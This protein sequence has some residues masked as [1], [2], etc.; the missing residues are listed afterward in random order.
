MSKS[1]PDTNSRFRFVVEYHAFVVHFQLLR[2]VARAFSCKDRLTSVFVIGGRASLC[3]CATGGAELL[4]V[5]IEGLAVKTKQINDW[6][7]VVA[8]VGVVVGLL[9]VALELRENSRVA[10]E[11]GIVAMSA[12]YSNFLSRLDDPAAC[13]LM[14][15][16]ME[17]SGEFSA[18]ESLQLASLYLELVNA[19][20]SDFVI[21][22]SR[23][24]SSDIMVTA[25]AST[26]IWLSNRHGRAF[27]EAVRVVY[28]PEFAALIDESIGGEVDGYA[29]RM[30]RAIGA[31]ES[32]KSSTE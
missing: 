5:Q 11:Q 8:S 32:G 2:R 20:E 21:G 24:L 19:A 26:T 18:V 16:A 9:L 29:L 12:G 27:W 10:S 28:M 31:A 17:E 13:E 3:I 7:Q 22:E 15:R 6:L 25:A 23:G 14:V 30:L 1:V 4:G